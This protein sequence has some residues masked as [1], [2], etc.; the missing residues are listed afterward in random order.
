MPVG[1]IEQPALPLW[2]VRSVHLSYTGENWLQ[3]PVLPRTRNLGYEPDL[4]LVGACDKNWSSLVESN[5]VMPPYQDGAQPESLGWKIYGAG[6]GARIREFFLTK[7]AMNHPI[8]T[9]KTWSHVRGLS[10]RHLPYNGSAL[11]LS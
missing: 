10:P 11:H 5:H 1:C 7:E 4:P 2:A 6:D 8:S 9:G 3:A